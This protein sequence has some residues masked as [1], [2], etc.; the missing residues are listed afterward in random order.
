VLRRKTAV[1]ITLATAVVGTPAQSFQ[2]DGRSRMTLANDSVSSV[3]AGASFY[4]DSM[5]RVIEEVQSYG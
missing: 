3:T 1:A 2:Y 5:S 4:F